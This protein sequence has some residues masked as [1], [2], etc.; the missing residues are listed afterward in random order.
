VYPKSLTLNKPVFFFFHWKKS[1]LKVLLIIFPKFFSCYLVDLDKYKHGTKSVL[2][3]WKYVSV[4]TYS[5]MI[6]IWH[7][8]FSNPNSW[9]WMLLILFN[10][11]FQCLLYLNFWKAVDSSEIWFNT[12]F[13]YVGMLVKIFMHR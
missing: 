12:K 3:Y 2:L 13:T 8:L 10:T 1:I 5:H 6:A 7:F 11:N 9:V 4:S